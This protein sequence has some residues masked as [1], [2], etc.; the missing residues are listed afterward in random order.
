[1]SILYKLKSVKDNISENP[2]EGLAVM[3]VSRGTKGIDVL[4]REISMGTTFNQAEVKAVLE[5]LVLKIE[6]NLRE[7]YTINLGELGSFFVSAEG[8]IVQDE[9]EIRSYSVKLKRIT[10]KASRALTKRLKGA[11][12][13]RAKDKID[14]DMQMKYNL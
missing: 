13:E 3:A 2:K 7:G 11:P 5:I 9:K 1:M 10:Y 6:D 4:A 8:R 12:F 14:K